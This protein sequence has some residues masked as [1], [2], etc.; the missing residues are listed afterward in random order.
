MRKIKLAL[1]AVFIMFFAPSLLAQKPTTAITNLGTFDN[2]QVFYFY[3]Q[4]KKGCYM[5]SDAVYS[6]VM[7]GNYK[8]RGHVS[9]MI[10]RRPALNGSDTV[11]FIA[12]YVYEA[13]SEVILQ[14][15]NKNKYFLFGQD[16]KAWAKDEASDKVLVAALRQAKNFTVE[17]FSARYTKRLENRP[18]DGSGYKSELGVA[19]IHA[20]TFDMFSLNGFSKAYD[21]LNTVCKIIP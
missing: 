6:Q 10:T 8:N 13:G 16:D 3:E 1:L 2:W 21:L 9:L 20:K 4:G 5:I 15:D 18:V 7:E 14:I 17:G 12:G 19:L 11:T